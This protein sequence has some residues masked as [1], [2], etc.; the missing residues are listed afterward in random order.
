MGGITGGGT[1]TSQGGATQTGG[2]GKGGGSGGQSLN[3]LLQNSQLGKSLQGG[4]QPLGGQV[5]P[6]PTTATQQGTLNSAGYQ[7]S[8]MTPAVTEAPAPQGQQNFGQMSIADWVAK[9]PAPGAGRDA[10][11][12]WIVSRPNNRPT[13]PFSL[14][15]QAGRM[16]NPP[17]LPAAASDQAQA[18]ILGGP[19]AG[20]ST[21]ADGGAV[22]G[23][24]Q[25]PSGAGSMG[26]ANY[27]AGLTGPS[28]YGQPGMYG[29]K[30]L[31]I[32]SPFAGGWTPS[33]ASDVGLSAINRMGGEMNYG[34]P[35]AA[36]GQNDAI[37]AMI[38]AQTP[39]APARSR[40]GTS[41]SPTRHEN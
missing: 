27:S 13:N 3:Q 14:I 4:L 28:A 26:Y 31:G 41:Y 18:A 7:T 12:A 30:S 21:F 25:A 36:G 23:V 38:D 9:R 29:V 33:Y 34:I 17:T 5:P 10:M 39:A 8:A 6:A 16:G 40:W 32:P 2:T 37:K 15:A 35:R 19:S 22:S 20:L 24:A 11:M 1:T